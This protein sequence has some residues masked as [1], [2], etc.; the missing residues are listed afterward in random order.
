MKLSVCIPMYNESAIA[1]LSA[2]MYSRALDLMFGD[3]YE[4]IFCDDGSLD[5]SAELVRAAGLPRVRVIG[6]EH[7]RGKGSAVRHAVMAAEGDIILYTDCDCAYGTDKIGEAVRIF[8]ERPDD[9]VVIGSRNLD[10][11]GYEGYTLLRRIM[12]KTYILVIKLAAG[13]RH[14]DSQCGFKAWRRDAAKAVFE[15][16]ETD[17]F[18]FDIEA[19]MIAEKLGF[20]VTEMPVRIIN[21]SEASSKVHPVRDTL[22]MLR[23]LHRIKRRVKKLPVPEKNK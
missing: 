22:R 2:A 1:A 19:L 3:D 10:G 5:G 17:G 20:R 4:L 15:R 23:D 14:S 6:Y 18:A 7:N 11:S 8:D 13:F 21:H 9:D 12:S 16:C